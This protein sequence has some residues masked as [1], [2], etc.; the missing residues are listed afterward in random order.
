MPERQQGRFVKVHAL[1]HDDD[2]QRILR[3]YIRSESE[4]LLTSSTLAF[5]VKENL[6]LKLNLNSPVNISE[7]TAQRWLKL[8]GLKYGKYRPGLY[9]DGHERPDVVRYRHEFLERFAQYEKLMF[10]Y[11]GDFMEKNYFAD[12]TTATASNSFGNA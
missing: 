10:Q 7:K 2:V 11:E 8:L 9:A 4:N 6:H 3:T 1:I 5:W 12:F